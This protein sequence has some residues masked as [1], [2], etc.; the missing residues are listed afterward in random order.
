MGA[1]HLID[2]SKSR[3][4]VTITPMTM[5][6][7][8]TRSDDA[9][10]FVP[11][12]AELGAQ[13]AEFAAEHDR[14]GTFVNEAFELFKS[15]GYLALAVP[16]ELGGHGATIRQVSYAQ[17]ELAKHC[18]SSALAV[19]MHHHVTLFTAWRYRRG[20]PGAEATLR[21]IA[22]DCI[23][24]VST[25]GADFTRPRGVA[26]PVEGG[27]RVSGRKVFASQVPMGDVFSTMFVLDDGGSSDERVILNMA[28]PV[29][30]DGV[31]VLD[32]WDTLG[33]RGT[34]SHD[35]ELD[36]VFVP[37]DKVLAR[38]PYGVV[39][40]PLQV[41]ISNAF[42]V[43]GAVYL[44]VAEAARDA[45]VAAVAGTSRAQDPSIQRQVGLMDN[46]LRVMSWALDG[47]IA[48]IGDDPQPSVENVVAAMA[49]KREISVGGVEVCDLAM[50]VAGGGAFF[51][52]SPIERC[53]RD[54][55]GAKF[56][57]FTPEQTLV[58]A[59]RV[60]LGLPV[61]EM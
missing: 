37:E 45:A 52:T 54:I 34:G 28:V 57:P 25:G 41:I 53:Y 36:G 56:H 55:R 50:E 44:G 2:W 35:V 51:K 19:S 21:R 14:D 58:H 27:F 13:I 30:T 39:D 42:P 5:T 17:R 59:G 11:W 33:M 20:L 16:T 8:T 10:A 26:V 23:V 40:P 24:L 47:A 18:G 15:S 12:A 61:D 43:I 9:S 6:E 32:N 38:R 60:C 46:R 48:T 49:A 4:V 7:T 31:T 22:D 1:V 3:S 29:K